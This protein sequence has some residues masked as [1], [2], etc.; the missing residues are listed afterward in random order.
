LRR[1][2]ANR[3]CRAPSGCRLSAP[4]LQH[5][6]RSLRNVRIAFR[7]SKAPRSRVTSSFGAWNRCLCP[8]PKGDR[9]EQ[10][11]HQ[12]GRLALV[13]I[14]RAVFD[15]APAT[16]ICSPGLGWH[17][18]LGWYRFSAHGAA[19]SAH[20]PSSSTTPRV[21]L[22]RSRSSSGVAKGAMELL[23]RASREVTAQL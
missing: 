8:A 15:K 9:R 5:S 7:R 23:Q 2:R 22:R 3:T 4:G 14:A 20:C 13:G 17:T 21:V 16:G 1:Y 19:F 18:N 10:G 12:G 11:S 6:S